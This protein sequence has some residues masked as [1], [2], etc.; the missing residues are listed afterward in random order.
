MLFYIQVVVALAGVGILL[1]GRIPVGDKEVRNPLASLIGLILAVAL[2]LTVLFVGLLSAS[3]TLRLAKTVGLDKAYQM[4]TGT[5]WWV[6][7]LMMLLS[8]GAA[9]GLAFVGLRSEA[10]P[11]PLPA[12]PVA[13]SQALE[14]TEAIL[15]HRD[16]IVSAAPAWTKTNEAPE[17]LPPVVGR[18]HA[19]GKNIPPEVEA[20]GN[21]EKLFRPSTVGGLAAWWAGRKPITVLLFR[22]AFVTVTGDDFVVVPFNAVESI[23]GRTLKTCD[24]QKVELTSHVEGADRL[25]QIVRTRVGDRLLADI[26]AKLD[27]GEEVHFGPLTV[28]AEELRYKDKTVPWYELAHVRIFEARSLHVTCG[29][30]PLPWCMVPRDQIANEFLLLGLIAKMAP[31]SVQMAW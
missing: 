20:L 18:Y 31:G 29:N 27:A 24:G 11:M 13:P 12:D 26:Q 22:Q 8:L 15:G 3:E 7:P 4:A 10:E 6:R 9:G 1:L 21:A 28:T 19:A 2:P 25:E 17:E 16:G 14:K 5:Y 30:S 23:T